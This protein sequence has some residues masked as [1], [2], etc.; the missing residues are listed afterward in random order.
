MLFLLTVLA[1][2]KDP[3]TP[4]PDLTERLGSGESRAGIVVDPAS[5]FS[6]IS[7]EGRV[8]DIKIYNDRVQFILQGDL[9]SG[10]TGDAA[11]RKGAAKPEHHSIHHTPNGRTRGEAAGRERVAKWQVRVGVF[12]G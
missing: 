2:K 8:G 10:H 1:C 12:L 9:N 6:G 3:E 11:A 4:A 5:L 7:A